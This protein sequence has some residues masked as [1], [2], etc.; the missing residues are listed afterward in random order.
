MLAAHDRKTVC[1]PAQDILARNGPENLRKWR[2][3][4]GLIMFMALPWR[5]RPPFLLPDHPAFSHCGGHHLAW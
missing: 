1:A 4:P 3:I 2:G 5:G